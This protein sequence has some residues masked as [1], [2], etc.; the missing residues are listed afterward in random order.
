MKYTGLE[1]TGRAGSLPR[2]ARLAIHAGL[3][4]LHLQRCKVVWMP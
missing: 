2:A 4:A 1:V 3:T